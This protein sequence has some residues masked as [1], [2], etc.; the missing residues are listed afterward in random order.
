MKHTIKV[1]AVF[2][3][4]VDSASRPSVPRRRID[5]ALHA[6]RSM[7]W[8]QEWDLNPRSPRYERGEDDRTP[9]SCI[10]R[11]AET[12]LDFV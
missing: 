12:H 11:Y 6:Q 3:T 9:L 5:L 1:V 7:S 8:G 2:T 10:T 4:P